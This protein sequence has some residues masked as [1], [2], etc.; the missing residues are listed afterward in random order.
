MIHRAP[1]G[2]LERFLAILI[3]HTSG[4]F[5]LWLIPNQVTILPISEKFTEYSNKVLKLMKNYEIRAHIDVRTETI[6]KR[7]RENEI[8]KVPFMVIIGEKEEKENS[9]SVRKHGGKNLGS[10]EVK[11][12]CDFI[13]TLL[14][15]ELEFNLKLFVIAFYKRR[16][17]YGRIRKENPHKINNKIESLTVRLVGDNVTQGV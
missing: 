7:I 17:S 11:S 12:F 14:K 13:K 10:M 5:P 6:G 3:E 1:F 4:N 9:V 2:S 8:S 16:R 15:K